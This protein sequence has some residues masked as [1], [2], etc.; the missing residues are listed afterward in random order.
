MSTGFVCLTNSEL[1][2]DT[3]STFGHNGVEFQY[4]RRQIGKSTTIMEL[5]P[6]YTYITLD[7]ENYAEMAKSDGS[8][9]FA[10]SD[11]RLLF[12]KR[13]MHPSYFEL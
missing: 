10:I 3:V 2:I 11:I 5:Y 6:D 12:M 8:L 1:A 9:F 13:N 7:D 4:G